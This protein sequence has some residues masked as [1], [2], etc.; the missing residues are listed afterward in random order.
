MFSKLHAWSFWTL[1]IF[2]SCGHNKDL[3]LKQTKEKLLLQ[4]HFPEILVFDWHPGWSPD[5][6]QRI[7]VVRDVRWG[8][9]SNLC[10]QMLTTGV[11]AVTTETSSLNDSKRMIMSP[12]EVSPSLLPFL[13]SRHLPIFVFP[14][15]YMNGLFIFRKTHLILN[16]LSIYLWELI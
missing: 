8:T 1:R 2:R 6:T 14:T 15:S 9:F 13:I 7:L 4:G 10:S 3:K 12:E 11:A 16:F 5:C